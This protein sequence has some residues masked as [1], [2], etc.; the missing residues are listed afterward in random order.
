MLTRKIAYLCIL[1][2]SACA[3]PAIRVI[4]R[5]PNN[6]KKTVEWVKERGTSAIVI[7]RVVF[8]NNGQTFSEVAFSNGRMHGDFIQYHPNG[9]IVT[10]VESLRHHWKEITAKIIDCCVKSI[11]NFL[12]KVGIILK[13]CL[14]RK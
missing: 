10:K 4:D 7:K 3:P 12:I 2:L 11:L 5:F 14:N 6:E 1:I 8:Y 9:K 13:V